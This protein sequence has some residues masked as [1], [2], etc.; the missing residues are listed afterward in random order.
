MSIDFAALDAQLSGAVDDRLGDTI[1][2]TPV[3]K[4][5]NVGNPIG[6]DNRS[7]ATVTG[8]MIE[9]STDLPF[10]DGDRRISEFNARAAKFDA[11]ASIDRD[12]FPAGGLPRNGDLLSV[13]VPSL[14]RFEILD[15]FN[16]GA[17]RI[18]CLLVR[19]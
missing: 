8:I 15:V 6:V 9:G 16:D 19:K 17:S 10:L 2:F 3:G 1:T 4:T 14:R 5:D 13:T 11:W 18:A 7:P 12:R